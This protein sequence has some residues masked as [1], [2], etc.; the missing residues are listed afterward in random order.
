MTDDGPRAAGRDRRSSESD[1]AFRQQ[2]QEIATELRTK[3]AA[4]A[5][6]AEVESLVEEM[7]GALGHTPRTRRPPARRSA[8]D[9]EPVS[10]ETLPETWRITDW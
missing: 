2:Q 1:L 8:S 10:E 7:A 3:A 6:P 9:D 5:R 4:W